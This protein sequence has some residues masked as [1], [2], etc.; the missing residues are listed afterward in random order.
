MQPSKGGNSAMCYN[1]M[2]LEDIKPVIKGQIPLIK[3]SEVAKIT[4]TENRIVARVQVKG[5]WHLVGIKF[6]FC[7]MKKFRR[8]FA[9]QCECT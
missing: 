3:I 8:S 2:S 4:V 6:Q 1:I 9:Q 7:M 5:T